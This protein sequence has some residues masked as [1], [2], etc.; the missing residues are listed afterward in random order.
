MEGILVSIDIISYF[1][2]LD[3]DE[4]IESFQINIDNERTLIVK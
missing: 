2:S 1:P 4:I 3:I